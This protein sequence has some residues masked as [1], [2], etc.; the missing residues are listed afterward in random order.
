MRFEPPLNISDEQIEW[1]VTAFEGAMEQTAEVLEG[2]D[3]ENM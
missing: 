2:I 3:F 1:A